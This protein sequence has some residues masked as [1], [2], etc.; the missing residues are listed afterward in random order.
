[1][2]SFEDTVMGVSREI[3]SCCDVSE[4]LQV[5]CRDGEFHA[6][7]RDGKHLLD[8]CWVESVICVESHYVRAAR[9]G[10]ASVHGV[11]ASLFGSFDDV[12]YGQTHHASQLFRDGVG[13]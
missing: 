1:M 10:N 11:S 8:G 12:D 6:Y 3:E 9:E 2:T 4:V 7:G 13:G 5:A